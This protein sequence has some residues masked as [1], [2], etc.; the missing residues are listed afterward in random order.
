MIRVVA[1]PKAALAGVVA[2]F[3]WEATLRALAAAG[4][5][6]F[7]IVRGLGTLVFPDGPLLAWWSVGMAAHAMVGALWAIF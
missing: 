6:L 7:D 1:L 5:P 4:L 3:A 2:A